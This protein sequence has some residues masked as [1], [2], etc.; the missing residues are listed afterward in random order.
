MK[1]LEVK[2]YPDP[3]L[4]ETTEEIKEI[5]D[6]LRELALDMVETMVTAD[7]VGLAGPQVGI[8]KKIIALQTGE[9]PKVF[10]NPV[11]IKYSKKKQRAEEGCLS[12]PGIRLRIRRPYRVEIKAVDIDGNEVSI[13]AEDLVSR[14]FQHEIDHLDGIFFINRASLWQQLKIRKIL[15]KLERNYGKQRHN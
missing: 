2:K 11:I 6:N 9:G 3:V 1:I 10:F 8:S 14:I 4:S 12:F 7:G 13:K 5:D 15:K